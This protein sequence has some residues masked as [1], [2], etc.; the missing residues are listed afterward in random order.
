VINEDERGFQE[1]WIEKMTYNNLAYIVEFS[2]THLALSHSVDTRSLGGNT[3]KLPFH[4]ALNLCAGYK[5][6]IILLLHCET[7][8]SLFY[9]TVFSFYTVGL[10]TPELNELFWLQWHRDFFLY[11]TQVAH[12]YALEWTNPWIKDVTWEESS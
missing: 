5:E 8:K 1:I 7:C 11:F 3:A 9:W 2:I 4:C 10:F 12:L 6:R